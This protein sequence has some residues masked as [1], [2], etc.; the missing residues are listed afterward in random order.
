MIRVALHSLATRELPFLGKEC[1]VTLSTVDVDKQIRQI[2]F[3]F[4]A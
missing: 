4:S 3:K 1:K 2:K